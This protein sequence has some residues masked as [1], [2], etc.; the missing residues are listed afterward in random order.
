VQ[1]VNSKILDEITGHSV[2]L[3]R[4]DAGLRKK[5]LK[6]LRN[7][8]KTLIKELRAADLDLRRGRK[9]RMRALLKQTKATIASAY[10]EI[11]LIEDDSLLKLARIAEVQA[12]SSINSAI[13]VSALSTGMSQEMLE[14]IAKNTLI[15]GAPSAE[16][17]TKQ[18]VDSASK[19]ANMVRQGVMRGVVTEDLVREWSGT[20]ESR[21]LDG[22]VSQRYRAAEALVR[23]S[24]QVVANEARLQ[25]Y[26]NNDDIVKGIEWVSTF[27]SRTSTTCRA[28]DSLQWDNDRQPIGHAKIFPGA[29]AHWNCR[30][31]QVS[32]LKS[33]EELGAKGK[34]KEIPKSTRSSM[35]G[36]VSG[37]MNYE[38]WLESK[39]E[40]FQK[41]VLGAG[42]W[43]LWK[44]GKLGFT[45]MVDQT[46]NELSLE[47]LNN[48]LNK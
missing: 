29:T 12:V 8:E 27:D 31:T 9:G 4:V 46:G 38:S 5:V 44:K 48:K 14:S 24:V 36:Q 2:D 42:K 30:S 16:W 35:D 15:E 11:D 19:F 10:A 1:S 13:K 41:E 32:V 3:L 22:V 6:E 7:L 43:K 28:L 33:W 39:P 40:D 47:Q 37:G 45:D 25:T 23:T 34:F 26:A 20:K 21:Y 18:G 17:W